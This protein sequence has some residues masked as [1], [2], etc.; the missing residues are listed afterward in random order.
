MASKSPFMPFSLLRIPFPPAFEFLSEVLAHL[1]SH[2]FSYSLLD[3]PTLIPGV[4]V[5]PRLHSRG[6]NVRL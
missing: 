3:S 4:H 5:V 2:L 6:L 1:K